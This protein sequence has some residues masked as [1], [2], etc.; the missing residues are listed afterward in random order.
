MRSGE[1][2]LIWYE[3]CCS[4]EGTLGAPVLR[5]RTAR[6]SKR[7][8]ICKQRRK[9]SEETNPVGTYVCC[10]SHP[11]CGGGGGG[12]GWC[13]LFIC[14]FVCFNDSPSRLIEY[15]RKKF[16]WKPVLNTKSSFSKYNYANIKLFYLS[17]MQWSECVPLKFIFWNSYPPGDGMRRQG[18]G[19]WLCH[20]GGA[21][22]RWL[23]PF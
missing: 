13:C 5:G 6:G 8:V 18:L 21:L 12:G 14:L 10:L 19:R 11:V 17:G 9:S 23:V 4:E 15:S 3:W 1:W 16:Y 20:E 2:A 22:I 7:A